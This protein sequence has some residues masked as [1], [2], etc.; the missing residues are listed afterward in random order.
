MN[1]F[2]V[3][4]KGMKPVIRQVIMKEEEAVICKVND[5]EPFRFIDYIKKD[6][7]VSNRVKELLELFQ[8][9]EAFRPFIFVS[10]EKQEESTFWYWEVG[11]YEPISYQCGKDGLVEELV[12]DWETVPRMFQVRSEQGAVSTIIHLSI[13][14]SILRRGYLGLELIPVG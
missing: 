14:E 4:Q 10:L 5:I 2:L 8:P 12:V 13:A 11:A 3:K 7:L 9:N 6:N 1:Y